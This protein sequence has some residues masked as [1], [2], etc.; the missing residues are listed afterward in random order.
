MASLQKADAVRRRR[1][2]RLCAPEVV[3][4]R[5]ADGNAVSEFAA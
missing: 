5:R 3:I 2:V 4:D 1:A